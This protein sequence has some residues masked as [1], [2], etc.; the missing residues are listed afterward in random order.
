MFKIFQAI[1]VRYGLGF[2]IFLVNLLAIAVIDFPFCVSIFFAFGG[3]FATSPAEHPAWV[4]NTALACI[5]IAAALGLIWSFAPMPRL[6]SG[7]SR[8]R[9]WLMA[10]D[11]WIPFRF[12]AT[13]IGTAVVG[14]I[15]SPM[16]L[17]WLAVYYLYLF[18]V[19]HGNPHVFHHGFWPNFMYWSS[20]VI[21]FVWIALGLGLLCPKWRWLRTICIAMRLL[22]IE[23]MMTSFN[24]RS[25][26][27][28]NALMR[29][30]E[31][32]R[33]SH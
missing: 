13:I 33:L 27:D 22:F 7:L 15:V 19:G 18:G 20:L 23:W 14:F 24:H 12:F 11:S 1:I 16:A 26:Q 5:A 32:D 4:V 25:D 31:R 9:E 8:L 2:L 29:C 17:F 21:S 30:M 3:V 6:H 28:R 10:K